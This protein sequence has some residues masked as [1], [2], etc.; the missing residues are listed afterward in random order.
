MIYSHRIKI[1]GAAEEI[2]FEPVD[3]DSV[4]EHLNTSTPRSDSEILPEEV[5]NETETQ[6]IV[7]EAIPADDNDSKK[8]RILMAKVENVYHEPFEM[9]QELKVGLKR[10][11]DISQHSATPYELSFLSLD[12]IFFR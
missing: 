5:T 11:V 2:A 10:N 3:E 9:T 8:N 1:T 7:E 12:Y 6:E 4:N